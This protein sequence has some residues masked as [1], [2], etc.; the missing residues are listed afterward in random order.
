MRRLSSGDTPPGRRPPGPHENPD[1]A[2][3]SPLR[4]ALLGENRGLR[5][6]DPSDA[7]V[8]TPEAE[9]SAARRGTLISELQL[10]IKNKADLLHWVTKSRAWRYTAWLR[11]LNFLLLR[12]SAWRRGL[13]AESFHGELERPGEGD[14][15]SGRLEVEGWVYSDGSFIARVE[16]FLDTISLGTLSHGKPRL[17]VAA[18]PSRAPVRCGYEGV[19][20]VDESFVGRRR[21][22]VRVMDSRR[23]I[24]DYERVVEVGESSGGAAAEGSSLSLH[25]GPRQWAAPSAPSPDAL[26]VSK[27]TLTLTSVFAL[28]SFLA[29][30][31]VV[32][33]PQHEAPE[34]SIIL[35]LYNRAELTLQCLQSILRNYTGR[36]QVIIVNNASTDETG[37]LLKRVR[38][39]RI[40]ENETNVHYLRACNQAARLARGEY[41]LLLNNDAQML[42]DGIASAVETLNSAEDIGAVGG[43]VV[44]P[45]GTLQ[46]AGSIIWRDGS[47]AGY[48]RGD[49]P[50]APAYLFR[51]DVDYCSGVFLL[52][53]RDL[54]LE[55]GGFDEAFAPAYYEETDYCVRLWKRGKRVVY[56]PR[57]A[58][59][60]YEFASS[61]SQAGALDLQTRH[62]KVFAEKH[63]DWLHARQPPSPEGVLNARSHRRPGQKR[64]L[65]LDDRVPHAHLG[66]GFP[67]SNRIIT[68]LVR[69]GHLLTCYPLTSPHEE[70]AGVYRDIPPEV[71]VVPSRGLVELGEFLAERTGYYDIVYVSRP[72]NMTALKSVLARNPQLLAGA[73]VVYDAEAI[74]SLR[75]VERLRVKGKPL[76]ER[77]REER[78]FGE[79]HLAQNCHAVISV[80]ERERL[81]FARHGFSNV[82][83]LGHTVDVRPTPRSFDE[84]RDILFVGAIHEPDSPNADSVAWFSKKVLPLIQKSL[85]KDVKLLVAGHASDD[86]FAGLN[87]GRVKVLGHVPD[88]T[89]LYDSARLFVAPTRFA[90]GLPYKV[91]EAAS[92]GLPVVATT[93]IGGH[94]GWAHGEELLVADH[95]KGF[96]AACA[97]LYR[98]RQLWERLRKNAL[99]RVEKDC[100]P[101]LFSARLKL[102][103][104]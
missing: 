88:L 40:I 43:R 3:E 36:Y 6:G 26:S 7:Q 53:R 25:E 90:A 99:G 94:L 35:V 1:D 13:R 4:L 93:L 34:T 89:E 79:V 31:S 78:V 32:E 100:S 48:G 49:S 12:V 85:G 73:R 58:V 98:D 71:E 45:D 65:Y 24:K 69:M 87:N 61:T 101:E 21:L 70:M 19:V 76:S 14:E 84:R 11:R 27:S 33:F 41:V 57:V 64:I 2:T 95:A 22:T 77:E 103:V 55:G 38:G 23:N 42:N 8:V 28:E 96:A 72:H 59:M 54:F 60:H 29:S 20:L 10:Q 81:E 30:G 92:H 37:A 74:F 39:A 63:R 83:M 52:T 16:V 66:S 44:L 50:F 97:T 80:S 9:T 18:Y 104:E 91:H 82:H 15:V 47:C 17:D 62:R 56:D 102:I 5:D 86:F 67:R 75:E 46:E 51:R 68:E